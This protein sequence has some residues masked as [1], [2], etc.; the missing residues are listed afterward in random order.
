MKRKNKYWKDLA[1]YLTREMNNEQIE[2]FLLE[3]K[4]KQQLNN[5]YELM[6]KTWNEFRNNPAEKYSDT[7]AAWAKLNDKIR[8]EGMLENAKP[9]VRLNSINY[10]IR[11]A[12]VILILL[13]VG[14]PTILY[15]YN[16]FGKRNEIIGHKCENGILTV[17]LPDGTRV[18]LNEGSNLEYRKDYEVKRNVNIEGEAFFNVMAD[19]KRPFRVNSGKVVVTVL[20]TSFNIRET[21]LKS[22]EVFVESGKVRVDMKNLD[23]SVILNPGEIAEVNRHLTTSE[24]LDPNYLSW[25]TKDFKF[26][27]E[28]VDQILRIL[29][30]SYHVEVRSEAGTLSDMRLTTEYSDQSFDAILSTICTALA[31]YFEKEGK[32]YILHT[33]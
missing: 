2:K 30:Q 4:D 19:P 16:E 31:L 18:F 5:D 28:E 25:K 3:L 14:I 10:F 13:A 17:D 21:A 9:I 24:Q 6:K 8:K 22:T 20:G 12:A 33:N 29:E 1:A 27:D 26:I 7:S 23:E 11:M 32:V 15:S